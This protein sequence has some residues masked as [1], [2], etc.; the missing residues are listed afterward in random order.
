M[1]TSE[2]T[3]SPALLGLRPADVVRLCGLNAVAAGLDLS[4]S[5]NVAACRRDGQRLLA[6]VIAETPHTV[7]VEVGD[8]GE[9]LK[10]SCDCGQP[11]PLACAHVAAT[12][13]AWITHPG[14]FLAGELESP[15]LP[16]RA[17]EPSAPDD[18]T[19]GHDEQSPGLPQR[20]SASSAASSLEAILA[21]M[22]AAD[23]ETI[24]R[25]ILG[26]ESTND[27]TLS[28]R[29][30]VEALSDPEQVQAIMA[31][32]D[33]SARM[34]L[35]LVDLAG[36]TVTAADIESL[37]NRIDRPVSAVLSD[38]EVLERHALLLPMLPATPPSQHGPGSS[39]RHVAGWRIPDE[40]RRAGVLPLPLETLPVKSGNQ[41]APPTISG[42]PLRTVRTTP[43]SLCLAL[44]L[45]AGAPSPL[46]LPH[47]AI[48]AKPGS[49][50]P[51]P[52]GGGI[53][54]P[55]ELALGPLRDLSRAAGLDP[56][57]VRLARRVLLQARARHPWQSIA[58]FGRVP[59]AERPV[60]LRAAFRRWL[61][62]ETAADLRDIEAV[63]SNVRVRYATA[64]PAFRPATIAREVAEARRFVA[65]L[66]GHART[67]RWYSM[68]SL[69]EL[70]WQAR[71]GFLR[72]Q[73]QVWATPAWWL[74]S[75]REKRALQPQVRGDWIAGEGAYIR[76][77]VADAC[78][79]WGGVDLAVSRDGAVMAFRL[80]AFGAFLFSR[81]NARPN[82]G[83]VALCDG[84]WGPVV[85]PVREGALAVQP[86]AAQ[87]VLL[88]AL[89]LWATPTA[90]SGRRLVYSLSADHACAAFDQQLSPDALPAILRPLH[91]RAADA[92][93]RQ[94]AEWHSR[95][96]GTRITTGYMLIEASDEATLVEALAAAT[97]VAAR[98]QRI[99]PAL[100]LALP[101][102]A[103]LL[104]T[105]LARRGYAV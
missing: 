72:G 54:A 59:I 27:V 86:I 70:A 21:R 64:H 23:V 62:A 67:D 3:P 58:D 97:E 47:V 20:T 25:R 89:A 90:V 19:S 50:I 39:W 16:P 73:Q 102:D 48:D 98:C 85:L 30:I 83:I 7:W 13:S 17:I 18:Q 71:P 32:L 12:L 82:Q 49:D 11:G 34:L 56:G 24:A 44:A 35:T 92:V 68:E 31:R 38:V 76:S 14:D 2:Q 5:H 40:S 78:A 69:I 100:A 52:S 66:L 91:A 99:G 57:T 105:L 41:A 51:A 36:G 79:V 84:D 61:R 1:A 55:G 65:R 81:E 63:D 75:V 6:T 43:R 28:R 9:S 10:W 26:A 53:L 103:E 22:H 93:A 46:G 29:R 74:E 4:A 88:D 96:G 95:W 80:N 87:P 8:E 45:I 104:R 101:G 77:V 33:H 94:L 60:V 37:A 42:V 15:V